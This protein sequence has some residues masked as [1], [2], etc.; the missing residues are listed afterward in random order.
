MLVATD[1]TRK[2]ILERGKY[3]AVSGERITLVPGPIRERRLVRRIYDLYVKERLSPKA[4]ADKFNR[5]GIQA[6]LRRP[7]ARVRPDRI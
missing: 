4:I 1:G 5:E 7:A 6:T 3:K 2:F